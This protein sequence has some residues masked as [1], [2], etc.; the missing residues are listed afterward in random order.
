MKGK[1][2]FKL[3]ALCAILGAMLLIPALGQAKED[4]GAA[5]KKQRGQMIKELKLAPEKEKAVLA[6]EDKYV[7]ER[8][9]IIAGVKKANEDLQAAVAAANPDE[10]KLKQ[11]VSTLTAGQDKLFASFK[12]QRDDE[13]ALMTPV[14]QAR[15]FLVL[16]K[17]R[18]KMMAKR[19]PKAA[20]E[21]E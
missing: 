11:L 20:A 12:N 5:Y 2:N 3:G 14:E 13:L 9:E 17:W 15:Y 8:K 19:H 18:Q 21:K 7:G 1:F 4:E 16:G 6:V 10:A